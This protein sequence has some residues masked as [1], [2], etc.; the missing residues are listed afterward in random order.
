MSAG[1]PNPHFVTVGSWDD[2]AG[3]LEFVPRRPTFTAGHELQ[4]ML[5]H[6]R[7]H[8][9]RELPRIARTLEAH[10]GAFVISQQAAPDPA[11]AHDLAFGRSYGSDARES[12]V[13]GHVARTCELGS[14]VEPDD[15]D[16]RSPA[17][18]VWAD[19]A[20]FHLVASGE[21]FV[22]DLAP[23]AASLY[24]TSASD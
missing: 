14:E 16:G 13:M 5:V 17:V 11:G 19:G 23:I 8:R 22:A 3:E 4:L 15:V 9:R 7:D 20:V 24:G 2:A 6:V 18:I 10:Y 21:M 1:E 12:T